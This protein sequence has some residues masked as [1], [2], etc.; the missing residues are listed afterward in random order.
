MCRQ[1]GPGLLLCE[2]H[3]LPPL[4]LHSR[5]R[6]NNHQSFFL[7]QGD[8]GGPLVCNMTGSWTLVGVVSW[9]Y[10]CALRD[11]PGVY[12]CVQS[13]LPWQ[14]QRFSQ[15]QLRGRQLRMGRLWSQYQSGWPGFRLWGVG[16]QGTER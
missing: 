5:I 4:D 16:A 3:S 9:G 8:S 7:F 12:E 10:G 14:M 15:A 1:P 13:F 11:I 6:A 2:S